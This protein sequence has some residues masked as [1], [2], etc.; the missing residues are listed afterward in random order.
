MISV[1]GV[2]KLI[3]MVGPGAFV[4]NELVERI[5]RDGTDEERK[6]LRNV[7]DD[8]RLVQRLSDSGS[9]VKGREALLARVSELQASI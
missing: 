8:G 3:E 9:D 7:I 1:V 4:L 6:E 5:L 2:G